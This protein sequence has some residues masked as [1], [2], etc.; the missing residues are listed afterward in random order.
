MNERE[1]TN[2]ELLHALLQETT[3]L[4]MS[5]VS[6]ANAVIEFLTAEGRTT[7]MQ[8]NRSFWIKLGQLATIQERL[9]EARAK[10]HNVMR[11]PE[12]HRSPTDLQDTIREIAI[13]LDQLSNL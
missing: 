10:L 9:E 1:A 6:L 7:E 13:I 5:Q 2:E 8:I 3:E 11:T 4:R 12:F